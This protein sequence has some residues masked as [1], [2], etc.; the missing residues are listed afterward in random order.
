[1]NR[2][3]QISAQ[4]MT[5]SKACLR[6]LKD[7]EERAEGEDTTHEGG[8]IDENIDNFNLGPEDLEASPS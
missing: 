6:G 3:D 7:G 5:R 8:N 2:E 1:M 4:T